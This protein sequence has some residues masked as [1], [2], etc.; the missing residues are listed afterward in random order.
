MITVTLNDAGIPYGEV[1][2]HFDMISSWA[3]EN[4]PSYSHYEDIDIS[5]FSLVHDVIADYFFSDEKDATLFRLK[6]S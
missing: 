3:K 5:D 1:Y 2:N 6:W 4:C